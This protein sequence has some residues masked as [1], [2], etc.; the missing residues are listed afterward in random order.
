MIEQPDGIIVTVSRRMY[1]TNGYRHWLRNFKSAMRKHEDGWC[2]WLR[3]ASKPVRDSDLSF[4]YL[5]IGNEIRFRGYYGGVCH[6]PEG[7][8]TFDD[9]RTIHG[10]FW[11]LI[12]GPL[13]IAPQPRIKRQGF[14]GF[15]YTQK[16]F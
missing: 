8:M 12:S 11:V 3:V 4:V 10:R 15:R 14:Q 7:F 16:L 5:C 1:E 13:E 9:G 6:T 2:Y